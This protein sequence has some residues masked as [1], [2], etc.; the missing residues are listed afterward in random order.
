MKKTAITLLIAAATP[1]LMASSCVDGGTSSA[2]G[3]ASGGQPQYECGEGVPCGSGSSYRC[4]LG[5]TLYVCFDGAYTQD[6]F[7]SNPVANCSNEV[8]DCVCEPGKKHCPSP[9]SEQTCQ[10]DINGPHLTDPIPCKQGASCVNE[11]GCVLDCLGDVCTE[12]ELK[13]SLDLKAV[14]ICVRPPG[15]CTEFQDQIICDDFMM[16]CKLESPPSSVPLQ[17]CVNACGGQGIPLNGSQCDPD[18]V[19]PCGFLVCKSGVLKGDHKACF[20]GGHSCSV[21]EECKSCMCINN[22]C[23]GD[24]NGSCTGACP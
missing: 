5:N 16:I 6:K 4:C 22:Q 15:E 3:S 11:Q 14:Q 19:L 12:G 21:P 18:P 10:D 24:N 13:C 1:W 2:A 8:G 9:D 17:N 7:C 23:I 20:P